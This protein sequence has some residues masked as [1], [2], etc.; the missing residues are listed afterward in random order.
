VIS[1]VENLSYSQVKLERVIKRTFAEY[2]VHFPATEQLRASFKSKLWRMGQK[3]SKVGSTK[4]KAILEGWKTGKDCKWELQ[5]NAIAANKELVRAKRKSEQQLASE[6]TKRLRLV[7]QIQKSEKE[8]TREKTAHQVLQNQLTTTKD[9][10]GRVLKV[11]DQLIRAN[12]RLSSAL[13]S[14]GQPPKKAPKYFYPDSSATVVTKE[15]TP[16]GRKPGITVL[17]G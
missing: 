9:K 13:I 3:L 16:H 4:R 7:N 17:G 1:N 11:N 2:D 14:Q 12:K 6:H 8:V 5:I 10:L 15:T